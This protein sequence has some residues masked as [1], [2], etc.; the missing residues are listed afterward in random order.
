[1]LVTLAAAPH[2]VAGVAAAVI[3]F[4]IADVAKPF[5]RASRKIDCPAAGAS[6]ATIW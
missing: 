2:T 6:S 3:L 1:V 5:R 4:R